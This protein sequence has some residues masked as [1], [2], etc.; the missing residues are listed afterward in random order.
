[1]HFYKLLVKSTFAIHTNYCICFK[2]LTVHIIRVIRGL[3]VLRFRKTRGEVKLPDIIPHRL[4]LEIQRPSTFVSSVITY[5]GAYPCIGALSMS[6]LQLQTLVTSKSSGS[7]LVSST[8][9]SQNNKLHVL[10]SFNGWRLY[11]DCLGTQIVQIR[12][13]GQVTKSI[14]KNNT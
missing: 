8:T 13:L 2:A 9:C 14:A 1:M 11:R 12:L 3:V 5:Q 10:D 6:L 7:Q 4:C